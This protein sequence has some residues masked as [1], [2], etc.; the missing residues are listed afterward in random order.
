[1]AVRADPSTGGWTLS[2]TA[3]SLFETTAFAPSG[4]DRRLLS[5]PNTQAWPTAP[6]PRG[7]RIVAALISVCPPRTPWGQTVGGVAH[8]PAGGRVLVTYGANGCEA[9][10]ATLTL[11]DVAGLFLKY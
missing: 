11:Q 10:L 3:A 7:Q 2:L 8:D 6:P 9:R 5:F 1:M 4:P